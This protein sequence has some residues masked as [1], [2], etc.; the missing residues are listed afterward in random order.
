MRYHFQPTDTY[1]AT[2]I[3]FINATNTNKSTDTGWYGRLSETSAQ[4]PTTQ[5]VMSSAIRDHS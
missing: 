4:S 2:F 1:N 5:I 3:E